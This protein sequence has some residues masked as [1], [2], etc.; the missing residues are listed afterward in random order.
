MIAFVLQGHFDDI[1]GFRDVKVYLDVSIRCIVCSTI[2]ATLNLEHVEAT[3][4]LEHVE[5]T[6]NLEHVEATLNLE[7]VPTL[8]AVA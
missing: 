5:A 3:L 7:H 4:N 1:P 8:I 2:E 6:L